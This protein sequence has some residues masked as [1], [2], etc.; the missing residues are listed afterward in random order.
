MNDLLPILLPIVLVAARLSGVFVFA[1][2]LGSTT[3]PMKARVLLV[4]ALTAA[5]FPS[6]PP[7]SMTIGELD[8]I[9]L[10]LALSGEVMIGLLVGFLMMLPVLAVQT[11]AVMMGQ[12]IGFGLANVF[13]PALESDSDTIGEMLLYLAIGAFVVMGGLEATLIA[14]MNTFKHVAVGGFA[15]SMVPVDLTIGI[16]SSGLELA[17][18]V[19]APLLAIIFFETIATGFITKSM[20]QMNINSIGFALKII[21]GLGAIIIGLG[22]IDQAIGDH[23]AEV[24]R[25]VLRW[26]ALLGA[27]AGTPEGGA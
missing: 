16:I 9:G 20:P 2:I 10:A 8:V 3:I 7:E 24:G 25:A 6:V 27:P 11:G 12:Q 21:L 14:T 4:L 22:S 17:I 5:T 19:S 13:N 15:V 1:P 23:I 26:S 18:R